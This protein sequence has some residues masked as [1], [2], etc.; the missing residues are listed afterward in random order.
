MTISAHG[1]EI[2]LHGVAVIVMVSGHSQRK[3]YL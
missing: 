3:H 1:V 2:G